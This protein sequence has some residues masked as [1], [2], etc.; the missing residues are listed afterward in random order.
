M[1]VI[2]VLLFVT[3]HVLR[4]LLAA[5]LSLDAF[6]NEVHRFAKVSH[7]FLKIKDVM[8]LVFEML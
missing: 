6:L 1:D 5:I 3:Q 7:Q 4:F 8:G 2:V